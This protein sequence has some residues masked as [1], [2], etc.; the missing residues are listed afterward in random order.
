MRVDYGAVD[1]HNGAIDPRY[2]VKIVGFWAVKYIKLI[3]AGGAGLGMDS[4]PTVNG[5]QPE[6]NGNLPKFNGN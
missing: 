4:Q 2:L 5:N 3:S 1:T 6:A